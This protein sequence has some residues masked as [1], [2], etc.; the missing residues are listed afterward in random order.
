LILF[1]ISPGAQLDGARPKP[2]Q[3]AWQTS[4]LF[5]IALVLVRFDHI[6]SVIVLSILFVHAVVERLIVIL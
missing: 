3:A 1:C 6:A 2:A 4:P 5:E